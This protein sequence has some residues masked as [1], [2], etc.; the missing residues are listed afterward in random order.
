MTCTIG[1]E[2]AIAVIVP[3][4]SG[5]GSTVHHVFADTIGEFTD[6]VVRALMDGEIRGDF[7]FVLGFVAAIN[8]LSHDRIDFSDP[9]GTVEA[10]RADIDDV[11]A[12][13]AKITDALAAYCERIG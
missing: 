12:A 7:F 5:T 3:D 4:P 6:K 8:A 2:N 1:Q 11:S 9:L 10:A 13:R